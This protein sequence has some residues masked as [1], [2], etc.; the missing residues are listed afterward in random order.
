MCRA[1]TGGLDGRIGGSGVG[2]ISDSNA[3][4]RG[5][6]SLDHAAL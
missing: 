6:A 3:D 5:C 4:A 1:Q 2:T